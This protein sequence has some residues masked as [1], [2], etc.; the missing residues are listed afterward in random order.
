MIIDRNIFEIVMDLFK[1][2]KIYSKELYHSLACL[3]MI[4]VDGSIVDNNIINSD[5]I[6]LLLQFL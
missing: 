5:I 6:K 4:L 3:I 1:M 2:H